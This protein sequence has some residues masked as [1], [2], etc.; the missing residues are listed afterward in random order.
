MMIHNRRRK[1]QFFA[2]QKA[3]YQSQL[4]DAQRAVKAGTASEEQLKLIHQ[5]KQ[6]DA[7]EAQKKAK[8]GI[9]ARSKEW[10]F[11]G[12]KK[13]DSIEELE[14]AG[15]AFAQEAREAQ[16]SILNAVGEKKE[17]VKAQAK[18]A[19]ETEKERQRHGGM[20]DRLGTDAASE[21]QPKAGG[22]TSFMT[23]R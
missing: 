12:M 20:L 21:E 22:W 13:D 7:E 23:R 6:L 8:K 14:I 19:L 17:D 5:E 15:Q 2:E 1:A 3:V 18:N 16:S 9:Y 4:Y 11:S 10:L